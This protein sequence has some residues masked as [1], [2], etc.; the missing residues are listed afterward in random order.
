MEQAVS[1][2]PI[3]YPRSV[4]VRFVVNKEARDEVFLHKLRFFPENIY[5]PLFRTQLDLT[6]I[7][8]LSEGQRAKFGNLPKIFFFSENGQNCIEIY[9]CLFK[10]HPLSAVK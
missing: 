8:L 10:D 2:R 5:Q 4:N 7:L 6:Y 1:R 3:F 9:S